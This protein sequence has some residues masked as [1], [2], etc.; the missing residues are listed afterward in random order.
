MKNAK[1]TYPMNVKP[2]RTFPS[3]IPVF[4]DWLVSLLVGLFFI[5][6]S[7]A[8]FS[9]EFF[10]FSSFTNIKNSMFKRPVDSKI[11]VL[12]IDMNSYLRM[13]E[14]Y[15]DKTDL[16]YRILAESVDVL[17]GLAGNNPRESLIVGID[18]ALLKRVGRD[19]NESRKTSG[20]ISGE[21]KLIHSLAAIPENM[22][23]VFGGVLERNW[24]GYYY[25]RND[26]VYDLVQNASQ[27]KAADKRLSGEATERFLKHFYIGNLHLTMGTTRSGYDKNDNDTT[28]IA[29]GYYPYFEAAQSGLK[30]KLYFSLPFLMY[31]LGKTVDRKSQT[32]QLPQFDLLRGSW[33][34]PGALDKIP[35]FLYYN[36]Y[37]SM[38]I[39]D[40]KHHYFKLSD[41]S[42]TIA[43]LWG[44]PPVE[45]TASGMKYFFLTP[46][47][48]PDYMGIGNNDKI[49]SPASKK[50]GYTGTM[51][52]V[53]GVM[54]HITALDNL[55]HKTFIKEADQWLHII[56]ILLCLA[57]LGFIFWSYDLLYSSMT[58]CLSVLILVVFSLGLFI[59]MGI[60][61]PFQMELIIIFTLFSIITFIRIRS[62][63]KQ[64]KCF[65]NATAGVIPENNLKKYKIQELADLQR[66]VDNGI[67]LFI[68]PKE[69]GENRECYHK[70]FE[71]YVSS[72]FRIIE[73][74]EGN[75][76]LY[77]NSIIGFWLGKDGDSQTCSRVAQMAFHCLQ[78][79]DDLQSYRNACYP[80][81]NE[82]APITFDIVIYRGD[83]NLGCVQYQDSGTINIGGGSF[84][85]LL[86][87][88][89]METWDSR[90]TVLIN[91]AVKRQIADN[92]QY[93]IGN[94][95]RPAGLRGKEVT[96]YPITINLG[97]MDS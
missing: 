45:L 5:V 57:I 93:K 60:F 92:R 88:G 23:I 90:N 1:P 9:N 15:K 95:K 50:S 83:Y 76:L 58:L 48:S 19:S 82:L 81:E 24:T 51:D 13:S 68:V 47:V 79:V 70:V 29:I 21:E 14:K 3:I 37:N 34:F 18:E 32:G 41:H 42:R 84:N 30:S 22:R 65:T 49:I 33:E 31:T 66:T 91:E 12:H 16:D 43:G 11:N 78:V 2:I 56:V 72:I 89:L 20:E 8:A 28:K 26:I 53:S 94:A 27:V 7:F 46:G 52:S 35:S 67:L 39:N 71:Y 74:G 69:L 55:L 61:F 44:R 4:S 6:W 77:N 17:A 59:F 10:L 96:L 38:D 25:L 62:T 85:P 80:D 54:A 64:N 87:A 40:L 86:A 97:G 36:F 75:H 63:N 73:A